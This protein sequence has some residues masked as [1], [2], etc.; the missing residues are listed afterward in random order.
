MNNFNKMLQIAEVGVLGK[1]IMHFMI[2]ILLY[3][4]KLLSNG[5]E[6]IIAHGLAALKVKIQN[7]STICHLMFIVTFNQQVYAFCCLI[8]E[9]VWKCYVHSTLYQSAFSHTD[10][11]HKNTMLISELQCG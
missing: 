5:E 4:L 7:V 6:W 11:S 8:N 1:V 2:L 3:V 9:V 10:L